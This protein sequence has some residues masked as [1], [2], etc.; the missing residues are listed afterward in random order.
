MA[1]IVPL[2]A[3]SIAGITAIPFG[4]LVMLTL[5][6]FVLRRVAVDRH[7]MATAVPRVAQ[8]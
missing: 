2:L 4:L 6:V 5:N 8:A 7:G 3:R 1:W